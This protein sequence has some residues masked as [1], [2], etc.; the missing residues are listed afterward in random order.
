MRVFAK[1]INIS[2]F[3]SQQITTAFKGFSLASKK[4]KSQSHCYRE[5]KEA[6]RQVLYK[7][8]QMSL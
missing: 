1:L 4:Q 3:G 2:Y 7:A 6:A 8:C 5:E